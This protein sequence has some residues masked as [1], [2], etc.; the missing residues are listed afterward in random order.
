MNHYTP[1][2]RANSHDWYFTSPLGVHEDSLNLTLC[3]EMIRKVR[4]RHEER[5]R[6]EG[7]EA[8]TLRTYFENEQPE[9]EETPIPDREY[10]FAR[11][12]EIIEEYEATKRHP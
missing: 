8:E 11:D 7:F 4:A 6:G 5:A 10:D 2:R 12:Q 9:E 1:L 3:Q